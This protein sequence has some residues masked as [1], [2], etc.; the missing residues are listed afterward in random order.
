MLRDREAESERVIQ[1]FARLSQKPHE[2][3]PPGG[4]GEGGGDLGEVVARGEGPPV[5]CRCSLWGRPLACQSYGRPAACPTTRDL[6]R[7]HGDGAGFADED[8]VA[9]A[10]VLEDLDPVLLGLRE[11]RFAGLARRRA[12]ALFQV[13]PLAFSSILPAN[14]A[15][16]M[17]PASVR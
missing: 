7:Q 8:Q 12:I 15:V 3:R 11:V 17:N 16:A 6:L 14:G 5:G 10:V 13:T 9:G 2:G 1:I 4:G